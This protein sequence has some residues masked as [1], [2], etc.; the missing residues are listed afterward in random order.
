MQPLWE[1]NCF[2]LGRGN[3][4]VDMVSRD[5]AERLRMQDVPA[6]GRPGSFERH[7]AEITRRGNRMP[8]D[9]SDID[10]MRHRQLEWKELHEKWQA[11][12][13]PMIRFVLECE[14]EFSGRPMLKK[15]PDGNLD[16]RLSWS[17]PVRCTIQ[18]LQEVAGDAE[19]YAAFALQAF[20]RHQER[21]FDSL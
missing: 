3:Y 11:N 10:I 20:A 13:V 1:A 5:G 8:C 17:S 19:R 21:R 14:A 9:P 4:L 6:G 2:E 7:L 15:A 12:N 18:G 16:W